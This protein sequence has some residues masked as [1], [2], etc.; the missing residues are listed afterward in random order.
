M[1]NLTNFAFRMDAQI[2]HVEFIGS[3]PKF[4]DLPESK[5]PEFC[6]WGRSN[7]GKSSLINY[8]CNRKEIAKV[9]STPGKTQAFNQY[10]INNSW[11]MMDLPGYGYARISKDK[12]ELWAQEI[13]RYLNGRQNLCL[14]FLLVDSSIEPQKIDI[15]TINDLGEKNIPFYILFTKTDKSTKRKLSINKQKFENEVSQ[16]WETL[17][18]MFETSA[19]KAFGRD[20]VVSAINAILKSI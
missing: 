5:F 8:L 12:K 2:Q 15:E 14:L 20:V 18:P 6:F 13:K 9:S 19:E 16:F 10:L 4:K 1:I 7:V 17:P 11:I 3:F